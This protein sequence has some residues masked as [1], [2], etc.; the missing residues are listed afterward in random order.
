M[1]TKVISMSKS[2]V[3]RR[4]WQIKSKFR[5]SLF[6]T[7]VLILLISLVSSFLLKGNAMETPNH[8]LSWNVT[9]GDT[10]WSI[11]KDSLPR[12]RDIRDYIWEI[13]EQNQLQTSNI[14]VGQQLQIPIYDKRDNPADTAMEFGMYKQK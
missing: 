5:L 13:K 11:A 14:I 12:G 9:E 7:L 1:E 2:V 3:K 4:T 8:Y 10:L 6:I